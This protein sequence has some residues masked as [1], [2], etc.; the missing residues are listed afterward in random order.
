MI[1]NKFKMI[2]SKDEW[3]DLKREREQT[4]VESKQ[5]T[6][7]NAGGREGFLGT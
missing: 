4:L 6:E 3:G 7:R 2:L 1:M 5:L